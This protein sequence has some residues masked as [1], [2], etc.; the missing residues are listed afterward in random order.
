MGTHKRGHVT[1]RKSAVAGRKKKGSRWK[2]KA[3]PVSK[4]ESEHLRKKEAR[5]KDDRDLFA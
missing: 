5:G 2:P 1:L 3:E 4:S